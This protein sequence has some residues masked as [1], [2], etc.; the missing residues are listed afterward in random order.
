M[1]QA[2]SRDTARNNVKQTGEVAAEAI[3]QTADHAH[4]STES[5]AQAAEAALERGREIAGRTAA[6]MMRL[7]L[8][9]AGPAMRD[10]VKAETDLAAFWIEFGREQMQRNV[11]TLQRLAAT[12][13]WREA[14]EIQHDYVHQS[15]TRLGQGM[16]RQMEMAGDMASRWFSARQDGLKKAA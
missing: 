10:L 4:E 2:S 1:A 8:D 13:D 6:P 3:D 11:Q 5:L 15:M 9:E 14:M 16:T 12:R 7:V